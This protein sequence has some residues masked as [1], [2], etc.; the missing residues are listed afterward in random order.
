ML[1]LW[2]KIAYHFNKTTIIQIIL[3]NYRLQM[4]NK[5]EEFYQVY[6]INLILYNIFQ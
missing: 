4:I 3:Y 2:D 5:L 6:L 1:P